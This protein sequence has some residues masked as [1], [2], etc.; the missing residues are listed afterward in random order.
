MIM[1]CSAVVVGEI[2]KRAAV[3][4]CRAEVFQPPILFVK[5]VFNPQ[6]LNDAVHNILVFFVNGVSRM[7]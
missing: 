1:Y 2:A 7:Y 4:E 3:I 6:Y 5:R